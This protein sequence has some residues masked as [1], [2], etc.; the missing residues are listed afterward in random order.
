[1]RTPAATQRWRRSFLFGFA[2]RVAEQLAAA[3]AR[4]AASAMTPSRPRHALAGRRFRTCSTDRRGCAPSPPTRS[5]VSSRRGPPLRRNGRGGATDTVRPP[6]STS[7]DR[8]LAV[9]GRWV[10]EVS[11]VVDAGR[12]AVLAAEEIAFGGTTLDL[13]VDRVTADRTIAEITAGPWWRSCGVVVAVQRPRHGTRSSSARHRPDHVEIQLSDEQL[14]RATVAHEL[15][16]ALATVARRHDEV[17]RAAYLDVVAVIGGTCVLTRS[18]TLRRDGDFRRRSPV[19]GA[20][21]GGGRRL[22]DDRDGATLGVSEG[23]VTECRLTQS[24]LAAGN[25]AGNARICM[26]RPSVVSPA[27]DSGTPG[28]AGRFSTRSRRRHVR[29]RCPT[30]SRRMA[31]RCRRARCTATSSCSKVSASCNGSPVRDITID[32]S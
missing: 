1:M 16:H 4:A 19:A 15:A 13:P 9:D 28:N 11:D 14:T 2:N 6:T 22:P 27:S 10:A 23:T 21:L 12:T 24:A 20:V 18:P 3:R 25:V 8:A 32:S 29:C 31:E 17:F 5:V 7:A 30:C 26:S